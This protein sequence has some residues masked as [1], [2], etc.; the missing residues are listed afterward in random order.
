MVLADGK[1]AESG[2][3]ADLLAGDGGYARL[4]RLQATG[5]LPDTAVEAA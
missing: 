4:F 5:Y 2:R 1:V 3:H